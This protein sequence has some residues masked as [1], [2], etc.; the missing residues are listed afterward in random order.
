MKDPGGIL[1]GFSHSSPCL[2][3]KRILICMGAPWTEVSLVC[4]ASASGEPLLSAWESLG[5]LHC[6]LLMLREESVPEKKKN[7][8]KPPFLCERLFVEVFSFPWPLSLILSHQGGL[9]LPSA[10]FFLWFCLGQGPACEGLA[11]ATSR[12]SLCRVLTMPELW[13]QPNSSPGLW[14]GLSFPKLPACTKYW[15][16]SLKYWR[17]KACKAVKWGN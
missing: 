11:G 3:L 14:A 8:P 10:G 4:T 15:G 7:P 2:Y 5:F 9:E 12:L 16:S 6:A 13:P 17:N 1:V